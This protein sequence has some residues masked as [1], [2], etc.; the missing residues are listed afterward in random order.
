LII[1]DNQSEDKLFSNIH[2]RLQKISKSAA[3]LYSK[4]IEDTSERK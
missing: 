4:Y 3:D 2:S 1:N